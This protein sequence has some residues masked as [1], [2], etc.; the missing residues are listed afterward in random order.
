MPFDFTCIQVLERI[1]CTVCASDKTSSYHRKLTEMK[2]YVAHLTSATNE[3]TNQS[4]GND[5]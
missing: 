5:I 4:N 3:G 1:S 2:P